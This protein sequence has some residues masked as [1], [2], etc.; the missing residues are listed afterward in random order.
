MAQW[1][2]ICLARCQPDRL[3]FA[4]RHSIWTPEHCQMCPHHPPK[5]AQYNRIKTHQVMQFIL[6]TNVQTQVGN[7]FEQK[8][9]YRGKT[10]RLFVEYSDNAIHNIFIQLV[11]KRW[12]TTQMRSITNGCN[13]LFLRN[14]RSKY[15]SL[16]DL[17]KK[18]YKS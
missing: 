9:C 15:L 16:F 2:A 12:Y 18:T 17:L 14:L 3:Q 8:Y 4:S 6:N 13:S 10:F 5:K 11:H 7:N 1:Q